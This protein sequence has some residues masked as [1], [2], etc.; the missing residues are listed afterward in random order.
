M[1]RI[2]K[3]KIP[4]AKFVHAYVENI[5]LPDN[6]FD[7]IF[8]IDSL[9]HWDNHYRGLSEIKRILDPNGRVVVI[10][11]DPT[12]NFGYFIKSME[13]VLKMGSAFFTPKQMRVLF[14]KSGLIIRKQF[15]IDSGTYVTVATSSRKTLKSSNT[16]KS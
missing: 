16:R 12:S 10:D 11:F 2:A 5:P 6:Y 13:W 8:A 7:C 14:S 15:Y 4:N 1:L 9:H 3:K